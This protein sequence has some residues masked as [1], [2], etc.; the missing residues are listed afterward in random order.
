MKGWYE[1]VLCHAQILL[2][3]VL[4]LASQ[5]QTLKGQVLNML[6]RNCSHE[7]FQRSI[8]AFNL[9]KEFVVMQ[10]TVSMSVLVGSH[11]KVL[12]SLWAKLTIIYL[13]C[14]KEFFILFPM[15]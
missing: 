1:F 11:T 10:V 4:P 15:R 2:G 8:S 7:S 3:F 6:S 12:N 9:P 5:K 13:V 14:L